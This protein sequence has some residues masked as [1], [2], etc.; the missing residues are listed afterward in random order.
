MGLL[1][2]NE[3][4]QLDKRRDEPQSRSGHDD[5]ETNMCLSEFESR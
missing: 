2:L 3:R 1:Q 5:E 4:L